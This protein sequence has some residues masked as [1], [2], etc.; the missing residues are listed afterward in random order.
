M[1]LILAYVIGIANGWWMGEM[2][3]RRCR[4]RQRDETHATLA[5]A[6]KGQALE[7]GHP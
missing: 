1:I 5:A 2:F 4:A 6:K 7:R 3:C